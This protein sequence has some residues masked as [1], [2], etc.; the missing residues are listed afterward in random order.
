MSE[1]Q[2]DARASQL[3][4]QLPSLASR[5]SPDA[6]AESNHTDH[7][8]ELGKMLSGQGPAAAPMDYDYG[9]ANGSGDVDEA[10]ALVRAEGESEVD[11]DLGGTM[12]EIE[13]LSSSKK[14]KRKKS[15]PKSQRGLN[16]PTGFEEYHT[17]GPL[18]PEDAA[19]DQE[20]FAKDYPFINRILTAIQRFERTRKLSPE[21]R[22]V[23]YKYL[24]YGG[25]NVGSQMFQSVAAFDKE[26]R[27]S[28]SKAE[29]AAAMSQLSIGDDKYDTSSSSALYAID[30]EGC[31][32]GFLSRRAPLLWGFETRE[33]VST[34]TTTLER[35]MD[36]LLQHDVCPEYKV[37]ILATRDHCREAKSELWAMAEASRWLPGDFNVACSTLFQGQFARN[38]DGATDWGPAQEG[39]ATFV[40]MTPSVA[41]Q[42]LKFGVAGAATEDV[43]QTF[44]ACDQAKKFEDRVQVVE[45]KSNAGFEI[46][47]I[48]SPT[49]DCIKLYKSQSQDFRPVGRV[50]ARPWKNPDAPP[51]DLTKKEKEAL[52]LGS[53]PNPDEEY[54]F[55]I[56]SV[57][58]NNIHIGF[59]VEATIH[60]LNC[61]IWFFDD[62]INVYPSFDT[63]IPN[64][65][66]SDWK[67]PR[68]LNWTVE[69][70]KQREL[71]QAQEEVDEE[72]N[73]EQTANEVT[74][75]EPEDAKGATTD[76]ADP[77]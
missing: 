24:A 13:H 30:F 63:Y 44:Q 12:V 57:I 75:P 18:R 71:E 37:Q 16:K 50:Y 56:E 62:V 4:A 8:V 49:K 42:V 68:W 46:I 29:L 23:F 51:E 72:D 2:E 59:R 33:S 32:K 40:G 27:E 25:V 66:M 55:F 6:D 9:H 10:S 22:D 77:L 28:M 41:D 34:V 38:Y 58:L 73:T 35:F 64:D 3:E 36:Y 53:T 52:T 69:Y 48:I 19:E 17:D 61:G 39:K 70:E 65:I 67:E 15:R 5:G 76:D 74:N 31:M 11:D 7:Q 1:T 60:K 54:V 14:K 47:S 26:S 21:R 45:T 43:Y 20:L